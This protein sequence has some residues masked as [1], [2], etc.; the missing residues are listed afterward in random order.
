MSTAHD[1]SNSVWLVRMR[2]WKC[3]HDWSIIMGMDF[4]KNERNKCPE[5]GGLGSSYHVVIRPK[6][7]LIWSRPDGA[8]TAETQS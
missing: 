1:L 4:I 7:T 5:C 2:C 6:L 3:A 8:G